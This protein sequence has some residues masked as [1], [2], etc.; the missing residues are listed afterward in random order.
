MS[1]RTLLGAVV[2]LTGVLLC[3]EARGQDPGGPETDVPSWHHAAPRPLGLDE[4]LRVAQNA[5]P[6]LESAEARV[7]VAHSRR[8]EAYGGWAPSVNLGY[9][10]SN[11][12]TGRLD[13]TGQEIVNTS[14]S[15][16]LTAGYNVFSGFSRVTGTRA[17]RRR[18]VAAEARYE[19]TR[20]RVEFEV[21]AAWHQAVAAGELVRAEDR[22]VARQESQ[23]D[24]VEVQLAMGRVA[25]PELLRA[26]VA[27]NNARMALIRA[28]S[29]AREAD[30]ALARTVGL[31][32]PVTP[33][34]DEVADPVSLELE[35]DQL[36]EAALRTGPGVRGARA[37]AEAARSEVRVAASR[38]LPSLSA[39][40]E[41]AWS[42][43][44]FP[45]ENR[46]W[47]VVVQGNY[48][49]FDGFSREARL[50]EARASSRTAEADERLTLLQLRQDVAAAY[51]L[52]VASVDA[53]RLADQTVELS[54]EELEMQRERFRLGRG[55]L[56]EVQEAEAGLAQSEVDRVRAHLDY[57]QGRSQLEFLIG[58]ELDALVEPGG[59]GG[60]R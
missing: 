30:F 51:D 9:A 59:D 11:S 25:R 35:L 43:P 22:R 10:Y 56:L 3:G 42:D 50:D 49:L 17:A 27:L 46:S 36:W 23:L 20:H 7:D 52:M 60:A 8:R 29:G 4:A 26:Q 19:E 41:L 54:R 33:R 58:T 16:Q 24:S 21:K 6:L 40:A 48:P 34:R 32:E 31:D 47:R 13:P 28:R 39:R 55:T 5:S 53:V 2:L 18:A 14:W 45:P 37:E 12:S 15:T 44:E 1:E 38:Y 57:H